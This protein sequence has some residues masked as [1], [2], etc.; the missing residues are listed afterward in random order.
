MQTSDFRVHQS[1][2]YI[3]IRQWCRSGLGERKRELLGLHF[4]C[5]QQQSTGSGAPGGGCRLLPAEVELI[6]SRQQLPSPA[7]ALV[8]FWNWVL[9]TQP[10]LL[11]LPKS[12]YLVPPLLLKLAQHFLEGCGS[13]TLGS[14]RP[15]QVVYKI[16]PSLNYV[17]VWSQLFLIIHRSKQYHNRL[18]AE[19][20]MRTQLPSIKLGIK[21]A[22]HS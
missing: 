19:G 16:L 14:L 17:S 5:K 11:A 18:N 22:L 10:V 21:R 3:N 8:W 9:E 12:V 13:E 2:R 15:F 7:S 1:D 6:N 20:D 4:A